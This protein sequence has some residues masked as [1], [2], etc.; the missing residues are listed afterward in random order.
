MR[1]LN[2]NV[3]ELLPDLMKY[4]KVER[5][6]GMTKRQSEVYNLYIKG[7]SYSEISNR[8]NISKSTVQTHL[9]RIKSL[10]S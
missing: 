1:N 4:L 2:N 9:S 8:L 10:N 5:P 7:L 6:K 3:N